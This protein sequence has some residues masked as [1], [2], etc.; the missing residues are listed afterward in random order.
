MRSRACT[1][2]LALG[3][4]LLLT[5]AGQALGQ[6][7]D[8]LKVGVVYSAASGELGDWAT[9]TEG[10]A[11]WKHRLEQVSPNGLPVRDNTGNTYYLGIDLLSQDDGS[12][13]ATHRS[14][15]AAMVAPGQRDVI[16]NANPSFAITESKAVAAAGKVHLHA[17]TGNS[18]VFTGTC[19]TPGS[20]TAFGV[21][22]DSAAWTTGVVQE[23]KVQQYAK[24]AVVYYANNDELAKM[25]VNAMANLQ[26]NL[27]MRLEVK[28]TNRSL[29]ETDVAA[30]INSV[31]DVDALIACMPSADAAL[32]HKKLDTLRKPIKS[33]FL[34]NGPQDPAW[35]AALGDLSIY[36][37]APSPW[38]KTLP[39]EFQDSFYGTASNFN[40][41]FATWTA[42]VYGAAE[43]H[44]PSP[45][46]AAAAAAGLVLYEGLRTAFTDCDLTAT[47]GLIANLLYNSSTV[48]CS[49]NL[50]D[51][52]ARVARN[53]QSLSLSTFFG[54]VAF[55]KYGQNYAA[56][57]GTVQVF[58]TQVSLQDAW[59]PSL[60][61]PVSMATRSFV[62]PQPNRY[63]PV[64]PPGTRQ[65]GDDYL[66]CVECGAGNYQNLPGQPYCDVC[67]VNTYSAT[68]GATD[69]VHCPNH[70]ITLEK[71]AIIAEV[72][73]CQL[74][75]YATHPGTGEACLDC[76]EHSVC[77]GALAWP[78]SDPGWYGEVEQPFKFYNCNPNLVCTGNFTCAT[79][80]TGRMCETCT[81]GYF[82]AVDRCYECFGNSA[83]ILCLAGMYLFFLVLNIG[84]TRGIECFYVIVNFCQL[85][86][87]INGFNTNWPASISTLMNFCGI[88]AF[89]TNLIQPQCINPSWGFPNNL[90]TQ[91]L[92]PLCMAVFVALWCGVTFLM[93]KIKTV[94][95]KAENSAHGGNFGLVSGG[96]TNGNFMRN[97]F[98]S[99]FGNEQERIPGRTAPPDGG[100]RRSVSFANMSHPPMFSRSS[101]TGTFKNMHGSKAYHWLSRVV[102]IPQSAAE[103]REVYLDRV[104]IPLLFLNTSYVA[105]LKLALASF[106][107]YDFMGTS[108][109]YY[110]PEE[111]CYSST[112]WKL[113]M[114]ATAGLILYC[115]GLWMMVINILPHL[116]REQALGEKVPLLLFGW[117]YESYQAK[118]FWYEVVPLFQRTAFVVMMVFVLDNTN[119]QLFVCFILT[120]LALVAELTTEAIVDPLARRLNAFGNAIIMLVLVIGLV[121]GNPLLPE[122][123][124]HVMSNVAMVIIIL[125]MALTTGAVLME[126]VFVVWMGV[127]K[128]RHKAVAQKWSH[129]DVKRYRHMYSAFSP[130]FL[131]KWLSNARTSDWKDFHKL[132]ILMIEFVH[133][134]SHVSYLSNK[135]IGKF[136]RHLTT[137]FPETLD[138]LATVDAEQ[139]ENFNRFIE[140]MYTEFFDTDASME[141]QLNHVVKPAFRAPM[142]QFLSQASGDDLV[143]MH[144]ILEGAF[145]RVHGVEGA[146]A[147]KRS[148]GRRAPGS[149]VGALMYKAKAQRQEET[150]L[151]GDAEGGLLAA[152]HHMP[153]RTRSPLMLQ[154]AVVNGPYTSVGTTTP[155]H[156]PASPAG[157]APA[158]PGT[159]G[160][161]SKESGLGRGPHG[162]SPRASFLRLSKVSFMSNN[163]VV[164]AAPGAEPAALDAAG[165]AAHDAEPGAS[166]TWPEDAAA[167]T[168]DPSGVVIEHS[169]L[170]GPSSSGAAGQAAAPAAG[171]DGDGDGVST[172]ED[173]ASF[174]KSNEA[175]GGESQA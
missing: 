84:I 165:P 46:A 89:E 56:T 136:W 62:I 6:A 63:V 69:C 153:P 119:V 109:M 147:I 61:A 64:C 154:L 39:D 106:F 20:C 68:R 152:H 21:T 149:S 144:K 59:I 121:M 91:L 4:A 160:R 47:G 71:G 99:Y 12:D 107:C 124:A 115:G 60:V 33:F 72:C 174:V 85:L 42:G 44:D 117:L 122:G 51:G 134:T 57:T 79:G 37:S 88:L 137:D 158:A 164:T 74:G 155:P 32:L 27:I 18:D 11:F 16:L 151:D 175:G 101:L 168:L 140:V 167:P 75:F 8:I 100:L 129:R 9:T 159:S 14:L 104:S 90:V 58:A 142:A 49:D 97:S 80:Y 105:T 127:L 25:C 156:S 5:I 157:G 161:T 28:Y 34:S 48:I 146:K 138:Y 66:P 166:A 143:F 103:W 116:G 86:S 171:T 19:T 170:P 67:P 93:Y 102:T 110:M 128:G 29:I 41:Q 26:L 30:A 83:V 125:F 94:G 87:V 172:M 13:A 162:A 139:R 126:T 123:T 92:L 111:Q 113:M 81:A 77:D 52:M 114:V 118:W 76:P 40:A 15:I 22:P 53:I 96:S 17:V 95:E 131:I 150:E 108:Y 70:T 54:N 23:Y 73:I 82:M 50:N 163:K 132:C 43:E 112:H 65:N 135:K 55:N 145:E 130:W 35:N 36:L 98:I 2:G 173:N 141:R 7:N 148:L 31:A 133:P 24:V 10:F 120:G 1:G 3:A 38:A 169:A 45:N 78:R